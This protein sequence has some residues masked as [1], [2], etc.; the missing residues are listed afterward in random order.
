MHRKEFLDEDFLKKLSSKRWDAKK[1]NDLYSKQPW[2]VGCNY[3]PSIAI[4]QLEMFQDDTFNPNRIDQELGWAE[5][6]GFNVLRI[7]LHFLLWEADSAAL[8]KK[9]ELL[10]KICNGHHMKVFF[11][12]L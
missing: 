7:Y 5:N 4:N 11:N 2:T 12:Q 1:A 9:L 3:I 10:L 8:K 6:L